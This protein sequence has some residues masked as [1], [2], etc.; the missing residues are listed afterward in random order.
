MDSLSFARFS[1]SRRGP[2]HCIHARA[3][4]RVARCVI[5]RHVLA[6]GGAAGSRNR[7]RELRP[8]AESARVVVSV[9]INL[10]K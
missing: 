10:P 4:A 1:G 8:R 3:R 2:A 5:E 9:D 6:M 7:A